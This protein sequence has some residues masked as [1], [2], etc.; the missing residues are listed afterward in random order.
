MLILGGTAWLGREIAGQAVLAGHD[1]SCLARGDSGHPASGVHVVRVDRREPGAYATVERDRWD[2]V[3]EVSW[4]PGFVREALI[5]LAD[6]SRHWI[7]ISSVSVYASGGSGGP[8][9]TPLTED[10][11]LLSPAIGSSANREQYGSAKVACESTSRELVGDRLLIARLGL[12]GGPGDHTDR[13]GYWV[14]RAA[15]RPTA[16]MLVPDVPDLPTQVIDV[17]DLARWLV[18]AAQAGLT[19]P[20]NAVGPVIPFDTWVALSRQVGGH[21]GR[22][23]RMAES[24]LSALGVRQWAGPDSL[25]LWVAGGDRPSFLGTAAESAGLTHRPRLDMLTD[26]LV[27]ERAH[28]LFRDRQA[29]LTDRREQELIARPA[30][31]R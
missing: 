26:T 16:P 4:Q 29:G 20:R 24:R 8:N 31:H 1:V 14:A 7:Y 30:A 12:I 15:R 17:R 27:W 21:V 13:T 11:P 5:A 3:I 23:V 28:G 18:V 22:V 25:P 10:A 19:G 2:S 6:R 9:A